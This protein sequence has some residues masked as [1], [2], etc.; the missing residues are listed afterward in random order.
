MCDRQYRQLYQSMLMPS[1]S[2]ET[3][4]LTP[5]SCSYLTNEKDER[6]YI[7]ELAWVLVQKADRPRNI[8]SPLTSTG[9]VQDLTV[10]IRRVYPRC[11]RELKFSSCEYALFEVGIPIMFAYKCKNLTNIWSMNLHVR[12][13]VHIPVMNEYMG[14]VTRCK[15]MHRS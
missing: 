9:T 3:Q 2:A 5:T 14:G 8:L 15:I 13:S 12:L 1:N 10:L 11:I 6:S 4:H 7:G